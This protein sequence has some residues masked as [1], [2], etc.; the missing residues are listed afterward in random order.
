M[1]QKK[2]IEELSN[3]GIDL[4]VRG[5]SE[6]VTLS[7]QDQLTSKVI[8]SYSSESFDESFSKVLADTITKVGLNI[9]LN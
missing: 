2:I 6:D 4:I 3:R 5:T 7:L 8:S 9:S 1:I